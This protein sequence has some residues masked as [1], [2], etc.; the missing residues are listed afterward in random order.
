MKYKKKTNVKELKGISS[1][2]VTQN[3][4]QMNTNIIVAVHIKPVTVVYN[5]IPS[6]LLSKMC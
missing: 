1:E 5:L 3:I 6:T 4:S 2:M